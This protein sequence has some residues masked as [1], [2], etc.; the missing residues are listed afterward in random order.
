MFANPF[1]IIP[2]QHRKSS[3]GGLTLIQN[4][5]KLF[6]GVIRVTSMRTPARL[7][8]MD[9]LLDLMRAVSFRALLTFN[10]LIGKACAGS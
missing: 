9:F 6:L 7:V 3:A 8:T 1:R 5:F 10:L 4:P 2:G